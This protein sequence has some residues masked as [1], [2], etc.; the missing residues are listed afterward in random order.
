MS[1]GQH[2]KRVRSALMALS[3]AAC[4]SVQGAGNDVHWVASWGTS[5]MVPEGTNVLAPELW[6]DSTLRQLVR[7]SL[8]GKWLRVRVSNA[9]GTTP[10]TI[11][12]GSIARAI[13]VGKPDI[14]APTLR[15]LTF[16]GKPGVMIPS[17]AEYYSDPVELD[18]PFGAD[19]AISLHFKGEP[20][21]QTGH[22]GSRTTSFAA[23]GNR[24][25][26]ATWAEFEKFTR[27]Y[28]IADIEVEA[29]RAVGALVA[30]GDSIT[31]GNGSTTDGNDRWPDLLAKR[32]QAAN[33]KMGVVNAGIGGGRMLRDGLGPNL[34]SR[35]DRDVLARSGV[36]HAIV[37]IGVNDLGNQRRSGD[38]IPEV[39]ARLVEDL[40]TAHRQV[41]AK[42]HAQGICVI[43]ATLTPYMGSDYYRPNADNEA[44]RVALND[45]IRKSDTFDAVADFDAAV[46][47]PADP[48]IMQKDKDTDGL[49]PGVGGFRAM[50]DAVPLAA[51][52]KTCK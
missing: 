13:A 27:W 34:V 45:W 21:R 33:M 51:L 43:G 36:T 49:H 6:R 22:P 41:V 25:A 30:I 12:A 14:D 37:L 20:V 48:R 18:H 23:K 52:A 28:V 2:G 24:V 40:K 9:F 8:P 3:F 50:V 19:F 35:F 17:G 11:E 4:A 47:D 10:L 31:D 16:G 44:D 1:P 26:D 29:P 15:P 5:Q 42:A 32:M 46:R 7:V 38:D 39:R